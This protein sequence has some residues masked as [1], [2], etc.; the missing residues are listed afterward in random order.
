MPK[1]PSEETAALP[2]AGQTALSV[3]ELYQCGRSLC[4]VVLRHWLSMSG[5]VAQF[6]IARLWSSLSHEATAQWERCRT[7]R[8][9][10]ETERVRRGHG[11][12][13]LRLASLRSLAT[14]PAPLCCAGEGTKKCPLVRRA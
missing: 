5:A 10:G 4:H 9:R 14:S 13:P 8:E 2:D 7:E 11:H 1:R 3:V 12:C 6:P